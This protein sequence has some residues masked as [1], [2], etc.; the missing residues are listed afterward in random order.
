MKA[1]LTGRIGDHW[2]RFYSAISYLLVACVMV[3][4]IYPFYEFQSEAP[5]FALQSKAYLYYF[6]Y[7][8]GSEIP[9]GISP[10]TLFSISLYA[11]FTGL[12]L[13]F[14]IFFAIMVISSRK[15]SRSASFSSPVIFYSL[16]VSAAFIIVIAITIVEETLGIPIVLH[17]VAPSYLPPAVN[18]TNLVYAPFAEETSFRIIPLGLLTFFLVIFKGSRAESPVRDHFSGGGLKWEENV[19]L[20]ALLSFLAPGHYR[21]KY[22]IRIGKSDWALIFL[23]SFLFGYA[24]FYFGDW[25]WGKILP[26]AVTGFFL[27]VGYVKFGPYMD[28]PMHLFFN[29]VFSGIVLYGTNAVTISV[30][31][32]AGVVTI[33]A[34]ISYF[35]LA[36]KGVVLNSP[37]AGSAENN[38]VP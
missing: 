32:V 10:F 1:A 25:G 13:L 6:F 21:K 18:F 38:S 2:W 16:T 28:I 33:I 12:I 30:L 8:P 37:R 24:H 35:V 3:S 27:A 26:A 4:L 31:L 5:Q 17:S 9:V 22:G 11:M 15:G 7:S 36:L 19:V 20:D 34:G 29:S 23:T 14:A